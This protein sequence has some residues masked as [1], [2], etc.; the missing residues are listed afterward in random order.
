MTDFVF[1]WNGNDSICEKILWK[2]TRRKCIEQECRKNK[3]KNV[4][5]AY[6]TAHKVH[7]ILSVWHMKDYPPAVVSEYNSIIDSSHVCMFDILILIT[8]TVKPDVWLGAPGGALPMKARVPATT[9][10]ARTDF[11]DL[12]F[13]AVYDRLRVSTK[14]KKTRTI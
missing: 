2:N 12:I 1:W 8:L 14:K 5:I 13:V 9:A 3:N 4:R 6:G 7:L 10:I 11:L